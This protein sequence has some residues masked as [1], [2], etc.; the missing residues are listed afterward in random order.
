MEHFLS[1]INIPTEGIK[2]RVNKTKQTL[3]KTPSPILC[4]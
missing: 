4:F 1:I 3:T 2:E